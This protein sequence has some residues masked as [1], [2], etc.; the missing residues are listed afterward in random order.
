MLQNRALWFPGPV[1]L[2]QLSERSHL[3]LNQLKQFT[4]KSAAAHTL[5]DTPVTR[6]I[7]AEVAEMFG[8]TVTKAG[9]ESLLLPGAVR[10]GGDLQAA[11]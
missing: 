7:I 3:T 9:I 4:R 10:D 11:A 2:R 5:P 6:R 1:T 8:A